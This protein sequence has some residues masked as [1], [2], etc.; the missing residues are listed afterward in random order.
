MGLIRKKPYWLSIF[1]VKSPLTK[2]SEISLEHNR[3]I[4]KI[5]LYKNSTYRAVEDDTL[6]SPLGSAENILVVTVSKKINGK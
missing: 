5:T 6:E 1:A 4:V 3:L 2:W